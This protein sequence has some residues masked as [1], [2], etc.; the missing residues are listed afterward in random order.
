LERAGPVERLHDQALP[1]SR[2]V[3]R[4]EALD[5][6]SL[7]RA[8]AALLLVEVTGGLRAIELGTSYPNDQ[9]LHAFTPTCAM[10][11]HPGAMLRQN[12]RKGSSCQ[13]LANASLMNRP[14]KMLAESSL[15]FKM[16]TLQRFNNR[17][18]RSNLSG[19]LSG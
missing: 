17:H 13:S 3:V 19:K 7:G 10:P 9:A 4:N 11:S 2:Q 6:A 14:R 5:G 1:G 16:R 18:R 12:S 15:K 8:I